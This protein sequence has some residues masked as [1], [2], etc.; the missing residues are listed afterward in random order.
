MGSSLP[1]FLKLN[2][3]RGNFSISLYNLCTTFVFMLQD[4]SGPQ[5]KYCKLPSKSPYRIVDYDCNQ[6]NI[7]FVNELIKENSLVTTN[8][9]I[10]ENSLVTISC[11]ASDDGGNKT[12]FESVCFKGRWIPP[13]HDCRSKYA[14][15]CVMLIIIVVLE[16]MSVLFFQKSAINYLLR[17]KI[18]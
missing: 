4:P 9:Y 18:Q 15:M 14:N 5:K 16:V 13:V 7:C 1:I 2:F 3:L 6:Q 17:E 10:K 11:N 8:E 12:I